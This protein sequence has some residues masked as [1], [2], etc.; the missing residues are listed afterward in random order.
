MS[1]LSKKIKREKVLSE[2]EQEDNSIL[3]ITPFEIKL[4]HNQPERAEDMD[5]NLKVE[6]DLPSGPELQ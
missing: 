5:F 3:Y 4:E 6:P 1:Q 2:V